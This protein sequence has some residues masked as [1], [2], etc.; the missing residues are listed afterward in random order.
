MFAELR[1]AGDKL[2]ITFIQFA[3]LKRA[4]GKITVTFIVFAQPGTK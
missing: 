1:R 2:T 3:E 4:G